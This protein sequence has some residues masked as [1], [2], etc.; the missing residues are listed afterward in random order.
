[1]LVPFAGP[2]MRAPIETY[3]DAWAEAGHPGSGK[4]A[5]GFHMFCHQ[6]REEAYRIAGPNI[7][8]YFKSLI[9]A[10]E[11]DA[12]WG[13]GASSKDYPD[14]DS[15]MDR[16][17]AASF[18]SLLGSGTVWVGTPEDV[19]QQIASYNGAVGGFDYAS[20]QVN[21]NQITKEQAESSMR[22]FA[23]VIHA[24]R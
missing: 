1:M 14:Y 4:I 3:R 22:L 11:L 20:L 17:R 13:A 2:Q 16:L 6:D 24:F 5:L 12:G 23:E 19:K 8:A 15:N 10:S 9:A 21:F 7:D 18:E